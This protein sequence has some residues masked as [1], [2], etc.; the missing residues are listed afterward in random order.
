[1]IVF[2]SMVVR[3]IQD[4]LHCFVFGGGEGRFYW[5][6]GR[7]DLCRRDRRVLLRALCACHGG[8]L[9]VVVV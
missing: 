5:V 1:M 4:T 9:G 7:F 8:F 6:N 2:S 3:R